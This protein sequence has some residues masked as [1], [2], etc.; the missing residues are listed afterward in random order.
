MN[1]LT[2][3]ILVTKK[4]MS[5]KKI[6]TIFI[7]LLLLLIQV[8]GQT[9]NNIKVAARPSNPIMA[10][11]DFANIFSPQEKLALENK[12]RETFKTTSNEILIVT[13]K[14]LDGNEVED[15]AYAYGKS[16]VPGNKGKDNGII[17]L[18]SLEPRKLRIEVGKGLEG[19]VP[20]GLAGSIM[21]NEI[22]PLLKQNQYFAAFDKGTNA[23]IAASKGEYNYDPNDDRANGAN[24][25][26]SIEKLIAIG[27]LVILFLIIVRRSKGGGPNGGMLTRRG[28]RRWGGP[29]V[30]DYGPWGGGGGGGIFGGGGGNGG[31]SGGDFGGFGGGDF[32]GGGASSDW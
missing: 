29:T 18:L 17:I 2:N 8:N 24:S 30:F 16:W 19:A 12:L 25:E 4:L 10:V 6:G 20:D 11:N 13:L 22:V 26:M 9:Y 5:A 31:S 1:K 23:I 15:V 7:V 27:A 14:S 32:G 28:Y 21:R 3:L